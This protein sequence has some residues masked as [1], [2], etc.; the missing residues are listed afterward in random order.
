MPLNA[1]EITA[2]SK[3]F[4]RQTVLDQITLSVPKGTF[5]GLVGG[6][7]AGKTTLIKCILDLCR[8]DEG[9]IRLFDTP[10]TQNAARRELAYL[11]ERF[12]PPSHL[13]GQ[14]FLTFMLRLHGA[15]RDKPTLNEALRALD[16]DPDALKKPIRTLSKG[17]TQ[18]LGLASCLL[19]GK[20]L[21][22]LDE[23]TSGLDPLARALLKR[24]LL[25]RKEQ[26]LT[27]FINT[28]ILT[29][30]ENLCDAMAILHHG[31]LRFVGSPTE[32][33]KRFGGLSL[34]ESY[35]NVIQQAQC[36]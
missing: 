7:G 6:N 36:Q 2:A 31:S 10:A 22:L 32:C 1:L 5:F 17:M 19:S 28:H 23:P 29:D 4:G 8:P 18:K 9:E 13:N 11:P 26:G 34:E 25:Q 14:E 33:R 16:M 30:V 27:L 3:R 12:L 24:Q 35:L 15:T 21:L 20:G